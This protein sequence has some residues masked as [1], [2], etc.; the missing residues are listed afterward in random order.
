M[1]ENARVVFLSG[2]ITNLRPFEKADIPRLTRWV[3]D[4]EIRQYILKT[5]PQTEKQEE[6]WFNKLGSTDTDIVLAVE[7]KDGTHI[8]SMGIHK[9]DW[10]NGVA[11]TGALIGEK[12]YWNRGFGTDAKMQV[13]DYLFNT[14]AIRKVCS[15]VIE[16]NERSLQYSLHCGYAI[17]GRRKKHIFKHGKYQDVINLG[18]F[19]KDWLPIWKKYQKTGSVK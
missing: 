11:T 13:L 6:E 9:I 19:R 10:R 12:E 18:L 2:K 17:E 7:T 14:L 8:G 5:Y 1:S 3:N 16:Y 15:D 4:P